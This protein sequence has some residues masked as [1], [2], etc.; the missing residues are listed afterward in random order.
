MA[1][2]IIKPKLRPH[3][4][5]RRQTLLSMMNRKTRHTNRNQKTRK[6]KIQKSKINISYDILLFGDRTKCDLQ[7]Q[8]PKICTCPDEYKAAPVS[9]S[10]DIDTNHSTERGLS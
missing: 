8:A 10:Y 6:L 4:V 7:L 9:C 2:L 5:I 3:R 1:I